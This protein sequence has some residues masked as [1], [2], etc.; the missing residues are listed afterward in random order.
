MSDNPKNKFNLKQL[1]IILNILLVGALLAVLIIYRGQPESQEFDETKAEEAAEKTIS[2]HAHEGEEPEHGDQVTLTDQQIKLNG[3]EILE[4]TP[5]H[6]KVNLRLIGEIRV[7][8]DKSVFVVPRL[9]G[10]VDAV[11]AN[12]GD[13]VKKGQLLAVI[14]SQAIADQRS[15]FLAA[16]KRTELARTTYE[17]EKKLWEGKIS[18]EQDYLLARQQLQEAELARQQAQQKLQAISAGSTTKDLTRYEIRSPIDGVITEKQIAQGQVLNGADNIY[19]ISDLS[20]VW[21]EMRIYAKDINTVSP[22]QKVVVRSNAFA[23]ESAGVVTYVGSLVGENTRTAMARVELKNPAQIWRPGV[24]VNIDLS[25][26]EVEVPLAVSVEALQE[27]ENETVVFQRRD[28]LF[29]A[30]PVKIGRKDEHYAEVIEGL[31]VGDAYA[32][33]NSY[34]IKA[35]L[36]KAH[37]E[38]ED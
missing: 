7:N 33:Q 17:R 8:A 22:G 14:S 36:G 4:A 21:A 5:K 28:Q 30:R 12:A 13:H 29:I 19:V 6:I 2:G 38:H 25:T 11:A 26:D 24:P 9:P 20:T 18:A 27:L 37:A 3:V 31:E 32:A 23:A 10:I 15:E 34:L 16:D 1:S 35:E